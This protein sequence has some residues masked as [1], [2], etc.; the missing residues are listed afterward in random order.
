MIQALRLF[1]IDS[2]IKGIE[3]ITD[4]DHGLIQVQLDRTSMFEKNKQREKNDTKETR[5]LYYYHKA[6]KENQEDY[7]QEVERI[8]TN[9]KKKKQKKTI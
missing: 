5:R 3:T 7:G 1:I 2:N 6:T 4:S 8:I 9:T